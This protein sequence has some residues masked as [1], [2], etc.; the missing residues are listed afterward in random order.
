MGNILKSSTSECSEVIN[1]NKTVY[2]NNKKNINTWWSWL[3]V[4]NFFNNKN[5][6]NSNS[7]LYCPSPRLP[8]RSV[9]SSPSN[10]LESC[11]H[12]DV[13]KKSNY[14]DESTQ[15]DIDNSNLLTSKSKN[16]LN[17]Q[18]SLSK[19]NKKTSK[20]S[21]STINNNLSDDDE[22]DDTQTV[23]NVNNKLPINNYEI[24]LTCKYIKIG[25]YKFISN[26]KNIII[27]KS[28]LTLKNVPLVDNPNDFIKIHIKYNDIIK[29]RLYLS[30]PTILFFDTN[31]QYCSKIKK[32]L[33]IKDDKNQ[34]TITLLPN[35]LTDNEKITLKNIFKMN[36]EEIKELCIFE[37][38]AQAVDKC[39][40]DKKIINIS[41]MK[42][43]LRSINNL[44]KVNV[45]IIENL[46]NSY[47]S[48]IPQSLDPIVVVDKLPKKINKKTTNM[49]ANLKTN[50]IRQDDIY[51]VVNVIRLP[52]NFNK[53][54][55]HDAQSNV[56]SKK[57]K[58]SRDY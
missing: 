33:G 20:K 55:A 37:R 30:K 14:V 7:K 54:T 28:G 2:Q 26:R 57:Q 24:L 39:N 12:L 23:S 44:Q 1:N 6:V 17:N 48:I 25:S 29:V 58:L 9:K 32:S 56:S 38:Q 31:K 21:T 19:K 35:E 36:F 11:Q 16:K 13:H 47:E 40:F 10:V 15:Y 46:V 42:K 45:K 51:P 41:P 34:I 27:N 49:L 53:R 50:L 8:I 43:K 3:G 5:P 18:K 22:D 4:S 52:K